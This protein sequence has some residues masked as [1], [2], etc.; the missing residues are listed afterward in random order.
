MS[1]AADELVQVTLCLP[2]EK[3]PA[4]AFLTPAFFLDHL[5]VIEPAPVASTS[6]AP[7]STQAFATLSGFRGTISSCESF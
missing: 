6:T 4:Q 3:L 2:A 5:A 7:S 1:A